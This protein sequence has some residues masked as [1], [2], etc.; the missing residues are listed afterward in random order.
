M[1]D[2]DFDEEPEYPSLASVGQ[3]VRLKPGT[4]Y[5]NNDVGGT[6]DLAHDGCFVEVTK[7]FW[8]YETGWRYHGRIL[9]PALIERVRQAGTTGYTPEHYAEHYPNNPKLAEDARRARDVFDP[10]RVY[11]SEHEVVT[12]V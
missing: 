2:Y 5:F 11:F 4:L 10:T 8:D 6:S 12:R 9:D 3:R 7:S 1:A